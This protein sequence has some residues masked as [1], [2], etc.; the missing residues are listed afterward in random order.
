MEDAIVEVGFNTK[1]CKKGILTYFIFELLWKNNM[2]SEFFEKQLIFHAS[3][4]S[5]YQ[6][7]D[8]TLIQIVVFITVV[9]V[10]RR[11]INMEYAIVEV[12][13]NT[14]A[15]ACNKRISSYYIFERL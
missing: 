6:I 8:A 7:S 4:T 13:F 5:F 12:Y 1:T 9:P 2:Y 11:I 14:I 3:S 10:K 15:S